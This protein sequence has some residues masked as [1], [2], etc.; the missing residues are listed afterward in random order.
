MCQTFEKYADRFFPALGCAYMA[1]GISLEFTTSNG[2]PLWVSILSIVATI[3]WLVY[4]I[5]IMFKG[6]K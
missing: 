3:W 5:R 1:N 4:G 2:W 6:V